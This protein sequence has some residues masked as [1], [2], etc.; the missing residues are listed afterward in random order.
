MSWRWNR[1][2]SQL[3]RAAA[4]DFLQSHHPTSDRRSAHLSLIEEVSFISSALN[5]HNWH[6]LTFPFCLSSF[7]KSVFVMEVPQL[8]TEARRHD[9]LILA[10]LAHV[11]KKADE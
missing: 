9:M 6:M 8:Q 10:T 4:E 3:A 5:G 7:Q 11:H 1:P 2:I